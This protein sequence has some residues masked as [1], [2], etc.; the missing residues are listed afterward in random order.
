MV[1]VLAGIP[2]L[3]GILGSM[4]SALF[5]FFATYVTKR[6]ALVAAAVVI[7]VSITGAFFAAL[8]ALIAGLVLQ[9]PPEVSAM[10]ALILPSNMDECVTICISA[11]MLRWVYDWNIR[12]IQYKLF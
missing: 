8:Q 5:S 1:A 4:F 11:K 9:V 10:A 12:I 3:A 2:W 6:L 7:I